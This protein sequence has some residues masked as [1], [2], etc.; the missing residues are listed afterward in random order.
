MKRDLKTWKPNQS[1]KICTD[2]FFE[3]DFRDYDL[4][5]YRNNP[6]NLRTQIRLKPGTVPNTDQETGRFKDPFQPKEQRP[7]PKERLPLPQPARVG[8][9]EATN[10][11]TTPIMSGPICCDD[12]LIDESLV[13]ESDHESSDD[14][15]SDY[16]MSSD[17]ESDSDQ[18]GCE[19]DSHA[20]DYG[21][22]EEEYAVHD[23]YSG[24]RDPVVQ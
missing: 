7:P 23:N 20:A 10:P 19:F 22:F 14:D 9:V 8:V 21:L 17:E 3:S 24:Y 13:P 11:D 18:A 1:T 15:Q 16:A 6:Q 4:M 12:T 2:H 5:R